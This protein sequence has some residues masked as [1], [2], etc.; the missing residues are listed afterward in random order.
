MFYEFAD[1]LTLNEVTEVIERHNARLGVTA[2]IRAE[3]GPFV[4]FNYVVSFD[5]SFPQF[6]GDI[7]DR[8]VAIIREC[9]GLTFC[10]DTGRILARKFHKF[11]NVN[12]VD[13][14]QSHRIDWNADHTILIKEDGSMITPVEVSGTIQWH[15]KMGDTDVA[16]LAVD[17]VDSHP[18]YNELAYNLISKNLTGLFEFCSRKQKIVIDYEVEKL[19]LLAVRD[20]HTGRYLSRAECQELLVGLDIPLV[21]QIPGSVRDVNVFLEHVRQL[22]GVEGYII[23][24]D[25]GH[26][27]KIKADE[28]LQLHNIVDQMQLEKNVLQ[29][30]FSG[31]LDDVKALMETSTRENFEK[32]V[33]RVETALMASASR[34]DEIAKMLVERSGGDRKII[35]TQLMPTLDI[36]KREIS[37]LYR[38]IDGKDALE[39]VKAFVSANLGT[40]PKVQEIKYLIGDHNWSDYQHGLTE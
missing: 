15:T 14:T 31:E 13:E 16:K 35:A 29:L 19:V 5:G 21:E 4:V 33:E 2:F 20:N 39:T 10:S 24:F 30:V 38:I 8:E 9:R 25:N 26:M 23:R 32:Y 1:N 17:F 37:L 28:Y 36:P 7:P 27:V 3:R 40:Q 6:G 18:Q 22:K 12:Q 34:L 11:F